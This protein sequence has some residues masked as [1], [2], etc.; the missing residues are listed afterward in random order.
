MLGPQ[1]G[2]PQGLDRLQQ[3]RQLVAFLH[4]GL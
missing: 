3:H 2:L 4:C 1:S